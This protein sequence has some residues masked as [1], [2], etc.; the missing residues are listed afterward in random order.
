MKYSVGYQVR[1]DNEFVSYIIDNAQSV[2]EVYFSWGD[3]ASGRNKMTTSAFF[4]PEQALEKQKLDIERISRANIKL[5]LLF[6]ANC[7]G[8]EALS[9]NFFESVGDTVDFIKS[10]Y[11]LGSV[12]TTSPIIARFIKTNFSGVE[13]RTSINME[14]GT[15]EGA[16]YLFDY[17]D[18]FYLKR[19]YNRDF[20]RIKEFKKFLNDNGKT[21]NCL[22]NS[23]CL[24]FC[25][26]RTFHDNL[27]AHE[28]KLMK[29]DNAL[30]FKSACSEFLSKPENKNRFFEVT[31][32]IRPEDVYLYEDLF[33]TLKLAT[34]VSKFPIRTVKAYINGNY[35]GL[36]T[37]LLEP[38]NSY[39][40][41]PYV[42]ENRL[43]PQDF[44]KVVGNCNKN[45]KECGYCKKVF[46]KC[47]VTLKE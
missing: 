3:F 40:L 7:Y 47:A 12:T 17:Y 10:N 46:E 42:L 33:D 28:D 15:K 45:C 36:I 21:L 13:T 23:G 4:T 41:Y 2:S 18:G 38:D 5:N 26:A 25:S 27:V 31:N 16:E 6:N 32:F 11:G 22:A 29:Q 20:K 35:N 43:I 30:I 19:E 24:N 9:R 14:I 37:D 34:R 1:N 44:G 39:F 8:E